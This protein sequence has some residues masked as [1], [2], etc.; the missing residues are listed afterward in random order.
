MAHADLDEL[1]NVLLPFAQD[2]LAKHG[3]FYPFGVSMNTDGQIAMVAGHDGDGHS[4][5]KGLIDLMIKGL[6]DQ[7]KQGELTATG[8]CMDIRVIPPA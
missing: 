8:I 7:A 3:E 5:S 1:V 6:R 2:M 4:E